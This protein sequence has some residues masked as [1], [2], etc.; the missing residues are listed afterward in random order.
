M[1]NPVVH[2]ELYGKDSKALQKFY[3]GLFDW[4]INADNPMNYGLIDTGSEAVGHGIGGGMSD[5]EKA[6]T[7]IYVEVDDL[8]ACLKKAVA[9]GGKIVMDVTV[10]PGMVTMA[11]FSDPQGNVVGLVAS[12]TPSV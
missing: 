10:I 12:E 9:A 8:A 7:M 2:F 5:D 11:Q 4:N 3:S 6:G 1:A